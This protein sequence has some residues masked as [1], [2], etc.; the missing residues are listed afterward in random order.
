MQHVV[1]DWNG[2]LF[3]D[4]EQVVE[5]VNVGLSP[6]GLSITLDDYREYY[7]RPVKVF[8]ERLL[9]HPLDEQEW[10]ELDRRFH[11][12]Y[13]RML[14]RARLTSDA[15]DALEQVRSRGAT[16]SLLSMFPHH[17]LVPLVSRIGIAGYFDRVDGL[18]GPAGDTKARYLERHLTNLIEGEEASRVL[19]IGDT[20]DDAMAAAH[21]G[22]RCVLYHNGSHH[23]SDLEGL[24]V[25][26]VGSLVEAIDLA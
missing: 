10:L 23:R 18:R 5:A 12:G 7:T 14:E 20:P 24:G 8:Y 1:W 19:V 17:E 6:Y 15:R 11:D 2:T 25:P 3:D 22:A 21:V 4:L 16:Q 13:R 26:V 9:Q